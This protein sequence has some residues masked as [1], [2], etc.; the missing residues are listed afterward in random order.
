MYPTHH[1]SDSRKLVE[2][3]DPSSPG[4]RESVDL[5]KISDNY[6]WSMWTLALSAPVEYF[7]GHPFDLVKDD[8]VLFLRWK[9]A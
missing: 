2:N 4:N 7:E 6:I 9:T 1:V 3:F 8:E 5:R